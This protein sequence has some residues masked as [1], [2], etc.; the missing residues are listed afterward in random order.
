MGRYASVDLVR[1]IDFGG[2]DDGDPAARAWYRKADDLADDGCE[3]ST[4]N[5]GAEA[6][7]RERLVLYAHGS[8]RRVYDQ[9]DDDT[10]PAVDVLA[11]LL[12]RHDDGSEA[13]FDAALRAFCA[14]HGLPW[15]EP[16]WL[17]TVDV[18]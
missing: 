13:D 1:G 5:G 2:R 16:R 9:F 11:A 14:K 10:S 17:L 15:R 7:E 8:R 6:R 18:S 12:D 3:M 4:P